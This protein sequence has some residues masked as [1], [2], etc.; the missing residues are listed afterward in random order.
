MND[1]I[2]R[3]LQDY[4]EEYKKDNKLIDDMFF[5]ELSTNIKNKK[6]LTPLEFISILSWKIGYYQGIGRYIESISGKEIQVCSAE[7]FNLLEKGYVDKALL[8]FANVLGIK[9]ETITIPSA[10]LAFYDYPNFPV[11]D[12]HSWFA[13]Y[14]KKKNEF[15]IKDYTTFLE[16]IRKIADD[17]FLSPRE[18]DSSLY[19]MGKKEVVLYQD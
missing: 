4:L 19:Q 16:D 13:L 12:R 8:K 11:I 3:R 15:Y 5:E 17:C 18:I 7:A 2:C 14:N 10:I 1:V 6:C 9:G